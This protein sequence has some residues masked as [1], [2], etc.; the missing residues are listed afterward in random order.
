M[1]IQGKWRF[2]AFFIVGIATIA[3]LLVLVTYLFV[4]NEFPLTT[5]LLICLI[6][7]FVFCLLRF[8]ERHFQI[9]ENFFYAARSGDFSNK[10][11]QSPYGSNLRDQYNSLNAFYQ[12]RLNREQA[13]NAFLRALIRQAPV[14]I[15]A[16]DELGR[17]NLLNASAKKLFGVTKLNNI[18][19][20]DKVMPGFSSII[21]GRSLKEKVL[22]KTKVDGIEQGLMISANKA[23]LENKYQILVTIENIE[24]ELVE[25]EFQAWKNLISVMTH[26]VMNSVTPIA[27]LAKTSVDI[28]QQENFLELPKSDLAAEVADMTKAITTIA[29]RSEGIVTF[30]QNYRRLGRIPK[31]EPEIVNITVFLEEQV[32]LYQAE[33]K[34]LGGDIQVV[35]LNPDIELR[36]DPS[37]LALV[38]NNLIRNAIES[39]TDDDQRTIQLRVDKRA[40]GCVITVEDSGSGMSGGVLEKIFVPFYTTKNDGSGIGMSLVRQL[41]HENGGQIA[42]HSEKGKGTVVDLFFSCL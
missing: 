16:F 33:I 36:A 30:V 5:A 15:L 13:E 6:G 24:N 17:I 35:I 7:L 10:L 28:L 39:F 18:H 21:K 23:L 38:F 19:D 29:S 14:A 42:L 41:V 2:R 27:S 11:S 34:A 22:F 26:E 12:E 9:V 4:K 31:A 1:N 3:A 25:A 40:P 37:H 32:Q 8:V 20:L